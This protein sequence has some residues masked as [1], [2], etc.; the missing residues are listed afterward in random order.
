M[1]KVWDK[2]LSEIQL[3][4]SGAT[5]A[6]LFKK[7]ALLAFEKN[8]ATIS[9]SSSMVSN[10]IET[11]YYSLLK[12]ALDKHLGKSVSL[13]FTTTGF[14]RGTT[15]DKKNLGP[16]F[17]PPVQTVPEKKTGLNS[18]LTFENF[19]V[20][21]TNQLA[22]AATQTVA[23]KLATTYNPLF[24]YGGVGVGKTHLM[25]A[26]GNRVLAEKPKTKIIY[27]MGEEFVNEIIFAIRNRDTKSFKDKFRNTQ[28]LLIDDIQFIAGKDTVQEEFF[29]TFN[30]ITRGGGQIVLTSDKPP[31]EI[32]KL[33]TRLVSRF[34][35]GLTVDVAP[36]DFGL[37]TAILLIKAK[38]RGI[39]IPIDV[40]K[41]LAANI[42]DIRKLEGALIRL[43]NEA[44]V[45]DVPLDEKLATKI[46]GGTAKLPPEEKRITKDDLLRALC[47]FYNLRPTQFKSPQRNQFIALPRHILMYFLRIELQLP[48]T[49]IGDF[50]GGRDHTTIMYGVAKIE[51]LLP[52][53][54]KLKEELMGIKRIIY[55]HA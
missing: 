40:A 29:H 25:Q 19:A 12:K 24:I 17:A 11:R 47:F 27:C 22:F 20:S 7:A 18:F 4:V 53:S 39:D 46:S 8:I 3:E 21:T 42:E 9:C 16:L 44:Q 33:E 52:H 41:I 38:L 36:P 1:E 15:D 26:I 45:L 28:I 10:L 54:P 14:P 48:L 31:S 51:K 13:I 34:E 50:L 55:E 23:Q 37:R 5:F 2:V 6:T 32:K 49:E 43:A 30:A 35:G